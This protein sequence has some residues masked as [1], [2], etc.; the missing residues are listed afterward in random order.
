MTANVITQK[1]TKLD[2]LRVLASEWSDQLRPD[3]NPINSKIR[4]AFRVFM[5]E[6]AEH[7]VK[8]SYRRSRLR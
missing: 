8:K 3:T 5:A 7:V 2:K 6:H 4:M 1:K